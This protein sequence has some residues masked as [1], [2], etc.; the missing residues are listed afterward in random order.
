MCAAI[1]VSCYGD[2]AGSGTQPKGIK[3]SDLDS[4]SFMM[5]YSF[6]MQLREGNFG[7]MDMS[8]IVKGMKAAA[9]GEEIDYGEFRRIINA[10]LATRNTALSEEMTARSNDFLKKKSMEAGVDSTASGLLYRIIEQG[11]LPHPGPLDTVTVN[12]EGTNL[13]GKVF[14]SSYDRGEPATFCLQNVIKGWSE[15]IRLVGEGGIIEL[16]IPANLAYGQRQT[17]VDIRP[18]E[19]LSFKVELVSIKPYMVNP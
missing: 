1:L 14:D 5:G 15:G 13:D 17:G 7:P 19:A 3:S 6:G 2:A 8:C 4:A 12:Y 16:F 18:N 9:A 10:L 11:S